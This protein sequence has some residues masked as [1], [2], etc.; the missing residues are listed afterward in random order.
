[1]VHCAS[2]DYVMPARFREVKE[3]IG[4]HRRTQAFRIWA[5]QRRQ[6]ALRAMWEADAGAGTEDVDAG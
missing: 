5:E 2:T 1:M 3:Y 4:G 6:E